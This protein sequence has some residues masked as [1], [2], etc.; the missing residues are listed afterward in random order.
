ME[1]KKMFQAASFAAA[2]AAGGEGCKKPDAHPAQTFSGM[3]EVAES[4]RALEAFSGE[5]QQAFT[6]WKEQTNRALAE[7]GVSIV[8]ILPV[9]V[10]RGDIFDSNHT[11]LRFDVVFSNAEGTPRRFDATVERDVPR[12]DP[13]RGRD[14]QAAYTLA[15]NAIRPQVIQAATQH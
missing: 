12:V 10:P 9:H 13:T 2:V 14:W 4:P 15:L 11:L 7:S 1:F 8:R 6:D 3:S 5:A